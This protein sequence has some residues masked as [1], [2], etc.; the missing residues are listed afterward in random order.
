MTAPTD[1]GKTLA[2][3]EPYVL[4]AA[5]ALITCAYNKNY[6]AFDL[7]SRPHVFRATTSAGHVEFEVP[8]WFPIQ[9]ALLG[10]GKEGL[11][12]VV[13]HLGLPRSEGAGRGGTRLHRFQLDAVLRAD[14]ESVS[15]TYSPWF[16]FAAPPH[17][18][19][20]ERDAAGY[21]VS[22]LGHLCQAQGL[23]VRVEVGT[24]LSVLF[25]SD[26]LRVEVMGAAALTD[27]SVLLDDHETHLGFQNAQLSVSRH[28]F[29]DVYAAVRRASEAGEQFRGLSLM[30]EED[31]VLIFGDERTADDVQA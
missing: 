21:V 8:E 7:L 3:V 29:P 28:M 10:V 19:E 13:K 22:A 26:R 14:G 31:R 6:A 16:R 1:D 27:M 25:L 17:R 18:F 4:L 11:H 9:E 15:L 30:V 24:G 2:A 23:R 20:L 5:S 12:S